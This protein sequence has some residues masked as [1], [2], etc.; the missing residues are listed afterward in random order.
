MNVVNLPPRYEATTLL[1]SGGFG[2]VVIC[3]DTHLDRLVAIKTLKNPADKKRMVDEVNA[4]LALRSKHVVQ[5]YDIID[6]GN[7]IAIVEEYIDGP[8]LVNYAKEIS[9]QREFL[10]IL[11]QISCGIT[12]IHSY[13]IIHRDIKP[14]NIKIDSESIVKI[15]DFGLS[16]AIDNASTMGFV[17]TAV[18]AAPELFLPVEI[19][20]F[21]SAVDIFAFAV[22]A[23]CLAGVPLPQEMKT[24]TKILSSNP[25]DN[26]KFDIHPKIKSELF[27][28]LSVRPDERPNIS[29]IK[30][31]LGRFLLEN[32]HKAFMVHNRNQ[33]VLNQENRKVTLRRSGIGELDISYNGFEFFISRIQGEV[34]VNNRTPSEREILPKSCVVIIGNNLRNNRERSFITFDVSHPEV[35]L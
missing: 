22:T 20:R 32:S 23:M 2:D 17:G 33:H 4:L 12:D 1:D 10:L 15:Y 7:T 13:G 19:V 34:T 14:N 5:L 21:T 6:D 27:K 25:F 3:N 26:A 11:W 24:P 18:F 28:C 30:G 8:N 31:L 9:N 35:L 16:R 29:E